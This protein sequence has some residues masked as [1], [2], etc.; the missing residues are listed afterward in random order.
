MSEWSQLLS[1]PIVWLIIVLASSTYTIIFAQ[2]S[3]TRPAYHWLQRTQSWLQT[4]PTMLAALPLLGL[5]GTITG[6]LQTFSSMSKGTLDLTA[7][8]SGGIAD[9]LITTQIGL[10]TVIP[11]W[12]LLAL[13]RKK[14]SHYEAFYAQQT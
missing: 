4:L 7:L 2:M 11:G 14:H 8:L 6:L 3:E 10:V 9:A 1:N 13:L 5:L 12:L